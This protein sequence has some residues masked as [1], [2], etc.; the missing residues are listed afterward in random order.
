MQKKLFFTFF[1]LHSSFLILKAQPQVLVPDVQIKKIM[2]VNRSFCARI[3]MN[4]LD[5]Q[6]YFLTFFGNVYKLEKDLNGNFYDTLAYDTTDHGINYLQ[7]ILFVDSSL[8][9]LGNFK[10]RGQ[11]GFGLLMRGD[12][13]SN[14][15]RIWKTVLR[16]DPY[17]SAA[18]LFDHAFSAITTNFNQDS[19]WISS[20][21]RTDHGEVQDLNGLYPNTRE[22]ALTSAIFKIPI[23]S[24][25]LFLPNDSMLLDASGYVF[26]RGVRNT[27][28][29]AFAG[30]GHLFGLENSGERD[31]PEEMN[32]L[33]HGHHYGFPWMAGNHFNPQQFAGF[34]PD[35]DLLINKNSLAYQRG[36]FYNDSTFPQKPINLK[37]TLPLQNFG[38]DADIYRDSITG[39]IVD[40]SQNGFSISS[41]SPHRSPLGLVFD[42]DSAMGN[43]YTGMG[44][45]L[46][47]THGGDSSGFH[48][49]Y[50]NP[51]VAADSSRDLCQLIL[52]YDSLLQN[53]S[54]Q[55]KKLIHGFRGPVDAEIVGN[56]IYVLEYGDANQNNKAIWEFTFP[57]NTTGISHLEKNQNLFKIYPNSNK[58]E[59]TI[60]LKAKNQSKIQIEI[61]NSLG[62]MIEKHSLESSKQS[63]SLKNK[64]TGFY[65]IVVRQGNYFASEKMI[66]Y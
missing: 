53:Y 21:S 13:Q 10:Q 22:T 25:N 5:S 36:F 19:L 38:P 16:T 66:V 60:E 37:L 57:R 47:Y 58:G 3:A 12:L 41:F 9:L 35:S 65:Q 27:F 33:R 28:D 30:N 29:M 45:M 61:Y 59:F 48:P 52:T 8:F 7:G 14:G 39:K 54:L 44:F 32:W 15:T 4:P 31:D 51:G 18:V 63:F 49:Q 50:N 34:Q 2:D 55:T 64:A 20:G 1:I 11:N 24:E 46:S 26:A 6:L 43:S 42:V 23:G 17:P 62:Q 40:A 56:K